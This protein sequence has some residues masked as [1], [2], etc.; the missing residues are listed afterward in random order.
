[1][2]LS[3]A[4]HGHSM[5]SGSWG[6]VLFHLLSVSSSLTRGPRRSGTVQFLLCLWLISPSVS[7]SSSI[8]IGTGS[9][10]PAFLRLIRLRCEDGPHFLGCR[11]WAR[12][13]QNLP[14][15]PPRSAMM[16]GALYLGYRLPGLILP[17]TVCSGGRWPCW[18][19]SS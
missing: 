19:N 9:E 12:R 4:R 15:L 1:M 3:S 16:L 8:H 11:M 13:R 6:P 5:S 17:D 2:Q 10:C 18:E 7:S 14:G